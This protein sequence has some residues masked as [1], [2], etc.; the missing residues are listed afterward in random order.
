MLSIK[1][2]KYRITIYR[3]PNGKVP[4][5]DWILELDKGFRSRIT[6]RVARFEDGHFGDHKSLGDGVFE[7]RFFFGPGY[8]VYF[9]VHKRELILLLVGGDKSTQDVDVR[10]AKEFFMTYL[11]DQKNA[12]KKS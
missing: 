4:F 1:S 12:N 11:E 8:R 6:A 10:N 9:A 7:A 2:G 3:Q 5:T